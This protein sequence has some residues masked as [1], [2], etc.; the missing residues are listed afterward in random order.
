[1]LILPLVPRVHRSP[2]DSECHGARR[3]ADLDFSLSECARD[4]EVEKD[5]FESGRCQVLFC[6]PDRLDVSDEILHGLSLGRNLSMTERCLNSKGRASSTLV[7]V[8]FSLLAQALEMLVFIY[9]VSKSC[10]HPNA[11]LQSNLGS[12]L[13]WGHIR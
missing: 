3:L 9:C 2:L 4:R 7:A 5:Q 12:A 1:M 10:P 6:F 13:S 8:N 11:L